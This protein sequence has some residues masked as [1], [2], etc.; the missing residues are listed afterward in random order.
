MRKFSVYAA[1]AS[2]VLAIAGTIPVTAYAGTASYNIPGG[3]MTIIGGSTSSGYSQSIRDILGSAGSSNTWNPSGSQG[4]GNSCKPSGSTGSGGS[5]RPSGGE[6]S[7]SS[8]GCSRPEV[9]LP[10]LNRPGCQNPGSGSSQCPDILKPNLPNLDC[11]DTECPDTENPGTNCPGITPPGSDNPGTTPPGTDNPGTTNPGTDN[12]GTTP[13]GTDN[14]GTTKPGTT[15]PGGQ[16]PDTLDDYARQ[17]VDL[18]NAE[19]AKSGL[20]P[21]D[22][23]SGAGDAALVRAQEL[24]RSFSH[25]RP[26]GS[27]CNT[28]LDQAGVSYRGFGENIAYGQRSPEE[29]MRVWMN[30][31]GHRANILNGSFNAIGVGHYQDSAGTD[32]W[33]QLFLT[34]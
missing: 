19:R 11:P 8:L 3:R 6:N 17:V 15:N 20:S 33:C 18:V 9:I 22:V 2:A 32:Y 34:E 31:S 10:G 5:W 29:V 28:A 26:D 4:A 14:P 1:T 23:H 25:T 12:P 30:S 13:P 7:G 16:L 27:N 21:L 24:K